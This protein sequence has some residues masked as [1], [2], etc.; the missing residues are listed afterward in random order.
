MGN[1]ETLDVTVTAP[2]VYFVCVLQYIISYSSSCDDIT[3]NITEDPSTH[4]HQLLQLNIGGFHLCNCSYTFITTLVT[5]SGIIRSDSVL[6]DSIGKPTIVRVMHCSV[7]EL[8][9]KSCVY[10]NNCFGEHE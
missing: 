5:R 3:T 10:L 8:T 6:V 4:T 9:Y 2:S 7:K 1:T